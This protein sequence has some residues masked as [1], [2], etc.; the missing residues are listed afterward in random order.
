MSNDTSHTNN[1][2]SAQESLDALEIESKR[3]VKHI[4][5]E[6]K[7][8]ELEKKKKEFELLG[9]PTY[10]LEKKQLEQQREVDY[11]LKRLDL[12]KKQ[13]EIELLTKQSDSILHYDLEK[14][15]VKVNNTEGALVSIAAGALVTG[16]LLFFF[17]SNGT[18]AA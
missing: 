1:S 3:Q 2:S 6:L 9:Q 14:N 11:Q 15:Q 18:L 4:E 13:K 7:K 10:E 16:M 5:Y 12:A 8:L 17:R